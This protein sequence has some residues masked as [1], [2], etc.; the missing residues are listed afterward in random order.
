[1]RKLIITFTVPLEAVPSGVAAGAAIF[2]SGVILES[3]SAEKKLILRVPENTAIREGRVRFHF[4]D[5]TDVMMDGSLI[6]RME[7][8]P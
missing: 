1:M 7:F 8:I 4:E 5:G 2:L 6:E 3:R